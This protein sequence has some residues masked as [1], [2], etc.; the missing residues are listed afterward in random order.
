MVEV[1]RV[2]LLGHRRLC[3]RG[4]RR[5]AGTV[6]A[7]QL[8]TESGLLF[9]VPGRGGEGGVDQQ[10]LELTWKE[11]PPVHWVPGAWRGRDRIK[12]VTG[13][14]AISAPDLYEGPVSPSPP[15]AFLH[16]LVFVP[17]HL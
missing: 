15:P 11:S 2:V 14:D 1:V 12:M 3:R 8:L 4:K 16:D 7:H 9:E 10:T 13:G 17:P 5:D 6:L